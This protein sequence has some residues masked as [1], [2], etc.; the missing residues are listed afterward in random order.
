MPAKVAQ[1]GHMEIKKVSPVHP[2]AKHAK[3]VNIRVIQLE[4][5]LF[6]KIVLLGNT[7]PR[8]VKFTVR[9]V[10]TVQQV[11]IPIQLH[12]VSVS[13]AVWGNTNQ[14]QG[15]LIAS[16]AMSVLLSMLTMR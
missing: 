3:V 11:C 14:I 7:N 2:I 1:L 9:I 4:W 13:D 10:K 12:R 15:K 6:V 8:P 16:S 5:L